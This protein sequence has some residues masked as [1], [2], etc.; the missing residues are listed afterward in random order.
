MI[1]ELRFTATIND[2]VPAGVR[3]EHEGGNY[4]ILVDGVD[5]KYLAVGELPKV[6][7]PAKANSTTNIGY[8]SHQGSWRL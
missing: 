8:L 1:N 3:A 5:E 7:Q 6:G 4:L 2:R